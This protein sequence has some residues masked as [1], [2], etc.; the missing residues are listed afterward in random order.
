[1]ATTFFINLVVIEEA[2][3]KTKSTCNSPNP[4]NLSNTNCKCTGDD[5]NLFFKKWFRV[6]YSSQPARQ[7]GSISPSLHPSTLPRLLI[8]FMHPLITPTYHRLVQLKNISSKSGGAL[9][10][11]VKMSELNDGGCDAAIDACSKSR[12]RH[13]KVG[14][15]RPKSGPQLDCGW[16]KQPTWRRRLATWVP[17]RRSVEHEIP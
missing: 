1:M 14:V 8:I 11:G 15:R 16:P 17:L 6:N 7:E 4:C 3:T 5:G 13:R 9:L 2:K 10:W 12:G